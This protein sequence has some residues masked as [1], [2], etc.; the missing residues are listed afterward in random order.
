MRDR[1][2]NRTSYTCSGKLYLFKIGLGSASAQSVLIV[3]IIH[4]HEV[5]AIMELASFDK[6]TS[7]QLSLLN[8]ILEVLGTIVHSVQTR[9]EVERLLREYQI[10]TEELQSQQEELHITNEQ[11]EERNRYADE[12]TR[13]LEHMKVSFEEHA[14]QLE[15]ARDTNR[16]FWLTC[17]MSSVPA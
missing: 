7:L 12:R 14:I 1:E 9:V 11:L 4:N 5:N 3:P 15:I 17:P 2:A 6:F 10:M 8:D 13:E 16:S